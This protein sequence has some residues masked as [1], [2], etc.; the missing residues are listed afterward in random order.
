M[1]MHIFGIAIEGTVRSKAG[2]RVGEDVVSA[3]GVVVHG[4][5]IAIEDIARTRN[6][7]EVEANSV[8]CPPLARSCISDAS[9]HISLVTVPL[10]R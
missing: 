7:P 8:S 4:R 1:A 3:V 2:E 5:G 6:P 10:V 9:P